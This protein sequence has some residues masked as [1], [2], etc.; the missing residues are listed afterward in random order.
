MNKLIYII[1]TLA[2]L[3]TGTMI[4]INST[5][6]PMVVEAMAETSPECDWTIVEIYD[7]LETESVT[8]AITEPPA[9]IEETEAETESSTESFTQKYY[10]VNL[11]EYVQDVIF[12]ECEKYGIQPSVIIAM[13]ERESQF[14]TYAMGDDG[15]SFGLMQIQ[16]KWH[17]Q[18][19]IDMG[20]TDLFDPIQNVKVGIAIL[21]ELKNMHNDIGWALTAYNA[22][23]GAANEG[24]NNYAMAVLSRSHEI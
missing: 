4:L 10:N 22:G 20:C 2:V 15:R 18:R 13:I 5:T 8:E 1:G 24:L 12:A 11:T 9:T 19:M 21:G 16:P 7:D 6:E 17:L 23:M 3:I 14:Q